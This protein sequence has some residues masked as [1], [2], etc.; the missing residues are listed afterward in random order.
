MKDIETTVRILGFCVRHKTKHELGQLFHAVLIV[1][2]CQIYARLMVGSTPSSN[3]CSP[4]L[5]LQF[6]G[7][8]VR[9]NRG[10]ALYLYNV[11]VF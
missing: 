6:N 8:D 1:E 3:I 2:N 7:S 10:R 9:R 4:Q 11:R 5:N